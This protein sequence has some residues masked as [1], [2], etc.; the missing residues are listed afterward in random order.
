MKML[1]PNTLL[2]LLSRCPPEVSVL[3]WIRFRDKTNITVT[4]HKILIPS[5]NI[6]QTSFRPDPIIVSPCIMVLM[7]H[8]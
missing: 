5:T 3:H 8:F 1:F 7:I 4:N 6:K 2:F